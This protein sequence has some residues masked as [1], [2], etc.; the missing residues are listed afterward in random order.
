MEWAQKSVARRLSISSSV[1]CAAFLRR[2]ITRSTQ[3]NTCTLLRGGAAIYT[4]QSRDGTINWCWCAHVQ[5]MKTAITTMTIPLRNA[6]FRRSA[7]TVRISCCNRTLTVQLTKALRTK[8]KYVTLVLMISWNKRK[9][10]ASLASVCA[11][12]WKSNCK[13]WFACKS[14]HLCF[15]ILLGIQRVSS[16]N[17]NV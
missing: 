11:L 7:C 16:H 6:M 13:R 10:D 9:T 3:A 12:D 17:L 1:E 5:V 15:F 4:K 8:R 2:A 14:L